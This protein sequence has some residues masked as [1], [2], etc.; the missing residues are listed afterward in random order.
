[1][2]TNIEE[3]HSLGQ[4]IWYD[5][6]ERRLIKSGEFAAWI[7]NGEI[8]GL[9]SN[10]TIFQNAIANSS[11]Y[12]TDLTSLAQSGCDASQIFEYLA[13]DDIH[14]VADLLLPI[15]TESQGGDGY[16]SLEVNP[17]LAN[18]T[19][20]TLRDA[21]RLWKTVNR[22]NLM[23][24]IPA[25]SAGLPAIR[26]A[27]ASGI[28]VN[29]TLIFSIQRIQEVMQA[30]ISGLEDYLAD[31]GS[32]IGKIASVASFFVSRIDSKVDKRLDAIIN[33]GEKGITQAEELKGR[34]AIASA[35]I[36]YQ[37]FRHVFEGDKFRLLKEQG[38]HIQRPLWASTSTKNPN[39]P[40]TLYIDSL[41]GPNTVN[42][43]PHKTLNDFRD[44]G[45]PHLSI[46]DN[47]EEAKQVFHQ[48]ESFGI[49]MLEVTHELEDEGVKS[50]IDSYD[51]LLDTIEK[52]RV[53][54]LS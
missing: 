32:S 19:Y 33:S 5:N 30:Y 35:K 1:M 11:N 42:T 43:V 10:P 25:T 27:I 28:N 8:R 9:T 16:V 12:D 36:A 34:A 14:S 18:D 2:V 23:I 47:I 41:I 53:E 48:L 52:R 50:F 51:A 3:L 44:H 29:V 4:S 37:E 6:I 22:P 38:A 15:F 49:S 21:K 17:H 54:A 40:D 26:D 20:Q 45:K 31:N 39:Y 13:I 24:K 7:N 46:E